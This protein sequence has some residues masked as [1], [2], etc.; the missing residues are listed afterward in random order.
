M[1]NTHFSIILNRL[2]LFSI[3][4]LIDLTLFCIKLKAVLVWAIRQ[5]IAPLHHCRKNPRYV[6]YCVAV[7]NQSM[8][9]F[10]YY[11]HCVAIVTRS[12]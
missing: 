3:I 9:S 10:F 12:L 8:A 1:T 7:T 4:I 6:N 5:K 11:L 2:E